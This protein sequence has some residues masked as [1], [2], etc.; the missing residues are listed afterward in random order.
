MQL[1]PTP[2]VPSQACH[3]TLQRERPPL[4]WTGGKI[5][6]LP[7]LSPLL[8]HG[9]RLIEPF[10]GA[11]AVF[12]NHK[13][14][15]FLLN[16]ANIDLM[17]MW[18]ALRNRS[19]RYIK[20]AAALFGAA[21]HSEAAYLRIREEFNS[22]TDAYDRAVRLPYLNRNGFNGLYRVNR[23]GAYNV[24]YGKPAAPPHFPLGAFERASVTLR[25]ATLMNADFVSTVSL[26]GPGDV[27]YC[28]PPYSP[29]ATGASFT[30]YTAHGFDWSDH[31]LLV[32]AA[33]D[34][35]ARGATVLISNHDTPLTRALYAGFR[36]HSVEVSRTVAA[37]ASSRGVTPE[38]V[39]ILD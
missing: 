13:Y 33:H 20:D 31:A 9:R 15:A 4:K 25:R 19:D 7:Q 6:L 12:L 22:A 23:K 2:T 32:N 36:I 11:G 27:V 24:P 30:G 34:A 35:H 18:R 29:S 21:N 39:A 3:P 26:A 14:P 37:N 5:R 10:V 38:L 8:P 16:D 28:D 1:H 17:A